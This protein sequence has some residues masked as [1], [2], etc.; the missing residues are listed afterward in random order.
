MPSIF[1]SA[2]NLTLT[3]SAGGKESY[4]TKP[5]GPSSNLVSRTTTPKPELVVIEEDDLTVTVVPGTPC[6][7]QG[8]SA[9]FVSDAENRQGDGPG[10]VCAYHPRSVRDLP[11]L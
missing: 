9:A 1:P 5:P 8:C 2:A 4:S 3:S 6:K 7:R 11:P 10:T